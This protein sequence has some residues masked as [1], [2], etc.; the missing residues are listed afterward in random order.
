MACA[1]GVAAVVLW[2]GLQS[3]VPG[4]LGAPKELACGDVQTLAADY[5][6][7]TVSDTVRKQIDAHLAH[8]DF[9]S[10]AIAD[11]LARKSNGTALLEPAI[12]PVCGKSHRKPEP[13][14]QLSMLLSAAETR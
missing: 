9:C 3:G 12:C 14:S 11:M 1:G 7:G 6:A 5:I 8:C 13:E 2:F 10:K 4:T